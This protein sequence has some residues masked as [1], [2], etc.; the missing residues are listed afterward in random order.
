MSP[1]LNLVYSKG[2]SKSVALS[3]R[4]IN[5]SNDERDP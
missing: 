5:T 3:R 4:M 2:K 1:K